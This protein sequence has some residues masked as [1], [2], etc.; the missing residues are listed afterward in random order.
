MPELALDALI[1]SARM[2]PF[3]FAVY[4]LIEWLEYR[5]GLRLRSKV[6]HARRWGPVAGA[7][8]G[9]FPQCGF[10]VVGASLYARRLITV[11]TLIAL[12][13]ATSDEAI[14][15]ILAQ[16]E[17]IGVIV[18]LLMVKLPLAACTG[19]L[20]DRV[21]FRRQVLAPHEHGPAECEDPDCVTVCVND[22]GCC[23]HH[24][25][26]GK[27]KIELLL[28][29]VKHTL[30][31]FAFLFLVT[32]ALNALIAHVGEERLGTV[33]LGHSILQPLLC[34]LIGLIPNCAASV[35]I[36]QLFLSGGISFGSA[37][38]GLSAGA[39]LGMLVLFRENTSLADTFRI[40]GLLYGISAAAGVAIQL[41]FG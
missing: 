12:F 16:P 32:L 17:H 9:C 40:I 8:L 5:Y 41:L 3:L 34:A 31:V 15:V 10:S 36:T 6:A 39:G 25:A 14:P 21:L 27:R 26:D 19:L 35:A 24:V 37:I 23:G 18:P 11:G 4:L 30:S 13:L 20:L 33:L 1:D 2:L 38:A 28:H 7:L 29:P 22:A